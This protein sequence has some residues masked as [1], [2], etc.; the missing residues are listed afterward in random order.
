MRNPDEAVGKRFNRFTDTISLVTDHQHLLF[1][2]GGELSE[3][4]SIK[5]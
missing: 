1:R 5:R 4:F 2:P 3:I